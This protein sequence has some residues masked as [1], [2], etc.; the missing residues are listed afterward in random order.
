MI[1]A[2]FTYEGDG[3]FTAAPRF[4][5]KLDAEFVC[6]ATYVME[7]VEERQAARDKAYHAEMRDAWANLPEHLA[8]RF[9]NPTDF[10]RYCL[11]QCGFAHVSR[12]AMKTTKDA[13]AALSV[14]AGLGIMASLDGAVLVIVKPMSQKISGPDKMEKE[15]RLRSYRMTLDYA[16]SLIGTMSE[17]L[18]RNAREAA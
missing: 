8:E 2:L 1:P 3:T 9:P 16:A 5:D 14:M 10:R 12:M 18:Q 13:L 17:D 6:G 7:A 15:E 11:A 4:R